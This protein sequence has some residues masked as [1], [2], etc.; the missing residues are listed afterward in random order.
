MWHIFAVRTPE[1]DRF[2]QYLTD[3]G[4]QTI[5]HYPTPPHKQD[6]YKEWADRSY[7]ISEEI[8]RTVLS[9]PMSPV[10]SDDE[11]RQLVRIVNEY[12]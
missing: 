7:P 3:N 5:I 1:R 11:V 9:L 12:R 4:V 2:Q 6:A 10:L 8:H